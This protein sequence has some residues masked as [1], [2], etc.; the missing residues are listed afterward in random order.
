MKDAKTDQVYPANELVK[1]IK[2]TTKPMK[3]SVNQN[4]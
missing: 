2:F 1:F 3:L 4:K